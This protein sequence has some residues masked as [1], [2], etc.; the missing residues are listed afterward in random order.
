[1]LFAALTVACTLSTIQPQHS[2][3]SEITCSFS[4]AENSRQKGKDVSMNVTCTPPTQIGQGQIDLELDQKSREAYIDV[5]AFKYVPKMAAQGRGNVRVAGLAFGADGGCGHSNSKSPEAHFQMAVEYIEKAA[6]LGTDLVVLPENAFGRPG[7]PSNCYNP[8]EPVDGPLV[9]AMRGVAKNNSV[10]IV[11]PIHEKRG[12]LFYNTAV[13]INREGSIVGTYSKVFPVFG[14][15]SQTLPPSVR[16]SGEVNS[17]DSVTPSLA[18]VSTFDLD[19]GRIAVLICYDI[20]FP[21][22]WH[23]AEALGA[24][25]VVWPS[26][27]AT[28]DPSTF[29]YAR[30]HQYDIVCIGAPGNIMTRR[31]IPNSQQNITGFPFMVYGVVDI[32]Q[33]YVHWD[34]NKEKVDKL[35]S[36]NSWVTMTEPGPPF[37]LLSS[38]DDHHSV[39]KALET[40]NIET[41]RGYVHRARH[42]L[43]VLRTQT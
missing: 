22:L 42:G 41:N 18:G 23:Q 15:M 33:T 43:N 25:I 28:P 34:Y 4:D 20:N 17:P 13:V 14:N 2:L 30:I 5:Q 35:M 19:F 29:G 31:G 24:D 21:E 11:L 10:N 3:Q 7:M 9:T 27:M 26:A 37:Y 38:T 6:T 16:G 40:Y 1:M 36:E 8:G 12:S 39:R 32:D